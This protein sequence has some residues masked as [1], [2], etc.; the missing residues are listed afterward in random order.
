VD[1]ALTSGRMKR[2]SCFRFAAMC[3]AIMV[4]CD[5]PAEQATVST[6]SRAATGAPVST[7]PSLNAADS[8]SPCPRTGRWALCTLEKRLEQSGFV[9]RKVENE[10]LRRLGFT[11][12][13]TTYTL[14]RARLEIFLYPDE[15]ALIRD[16]ASLDTV[17]VAP[18]GQRNDWEIPPRFIRSGNLIAV[19]LTRNEQQAERLTLAITAGPPQR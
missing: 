19:F 18:R 15:D 6:Q 13:P 2:A 11:V 12:P 14:G 1:Q 3:G 7:R 5:R 17:V 10:N 8:S 9:P 16:L 4:G